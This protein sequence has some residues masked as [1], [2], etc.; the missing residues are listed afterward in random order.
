MVRDIMS[1]GGFG[2][3]KIRINVRVRGGFNS[4]V[5]ASFLLVLL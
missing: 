4:V 2:E 1:E 5:I 3:G